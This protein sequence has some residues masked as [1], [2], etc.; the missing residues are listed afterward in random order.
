MAQRLQ[1]ALLLGETLE[2]VASW[3]RSRNWADGIRLA[4]S[5]ISK[6]R[7]WRITRTDDLT[8]SEATDTVLDAGQRCDQPVRV[9]GFKFDEPAAAELATVPASEMIIDTPAKDCT[10]SSLFNQNTI[11]G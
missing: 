6:N 7:K 2:D 1:L 8:Q 10:G 3:K 9:A 5:T 11:G 4:P